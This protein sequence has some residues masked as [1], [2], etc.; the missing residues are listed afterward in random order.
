MEELRAHNLEKPV[1]ETSRV[2]PAITSA[3]QRIKS[4]S[5]GAV[6][7]FLQNRFPLQSL[8]TEDQMKTA[9][10]LISVLHGLLDAPDVEKNEGSQIKLYLKELQFFISEYEEGMSRE[11]SPTSPPVHRPKAEACP[12]R[13]RFADTLIGRLKESVEAERKGIF[14]GISPPAPDSDDFE[15]NFEK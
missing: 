12:S 5:P 7:E 2:S 15:Q 1:P 13:K 3:V 8:K 4:L 11:A 14:S 9:F 10:H 6:Y